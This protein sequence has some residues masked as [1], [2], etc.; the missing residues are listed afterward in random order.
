[1]SKKAVVGGY[2]KTLCGFN[3]PFDRL[4]PERPPKFKEENGKR[5]PIPHE[6][7]FISFE[8]NE[9]DKMMNRLIKLNGADRVMKVVIARELARED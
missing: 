5:I 2:K 1:M 6:V 3:W 7:E 8:Q 9:Q 4:P